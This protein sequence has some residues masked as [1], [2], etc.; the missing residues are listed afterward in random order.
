M[1][2]DVMVFPGFSE[3][4]LDAD[5]VGR[6]IQQPGIGRERGWLGQPGGIPKAGHLAPR[7]VAR[8][9]TAVEALERGRVQEKS[10]HLRAKASVLG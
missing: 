10:L 4:L 6:A 8:A 3:A 5:V 2:D 7:L 1:N 9:G